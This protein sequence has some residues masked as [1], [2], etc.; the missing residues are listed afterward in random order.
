MRDGD[1][2]KRGMGKM[3]DL[4]YVDKNGVKRRRYY[5]FFATPKLVEEADFPFEFDDALL[6]HIDNGK[7]I[8]EK[9]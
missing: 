5:I 9:M 1:C 4:S 2:M 7:L 3:K 8:I 6:V